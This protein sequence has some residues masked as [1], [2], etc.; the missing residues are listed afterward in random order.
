MNEDDR[1]ILDEMMG[2]CHHELEFNDWP[3]DKNL[4]IAHFCCLKC[5]LYTDEAPC[6]VNPAYDNAEDAHV[7]FKWLV[8]NGKWSSFRSSNTAQNAYD[9]DGEWRWCD[10]DGK[11]GEWWWCDEPESG[12]EAYLFYD[13]IRF[14][15]LMVKWRKKIINREGD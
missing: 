13:P 7:L 2:I 3:H 5:K 10:E 12:I 15:Q 9:E 6:E 1:N 8:D 4:P 11:N 14:C